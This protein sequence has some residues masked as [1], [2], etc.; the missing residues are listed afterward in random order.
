MQPIQLLNQHL[1][2]II[3]GGKAYPRTKVERIYAKLSTP[4]VA[5]EENSPG[6]FGYFYDG[7]RARGKVYPYGEVVFQ[8]HWDELK[9]HPNASYGWSVN[10]PQELGIT[11]TSVSP[12][13]DLITMKKSWDN[14]VRL[15]DGSINPKGS[16]LYTNHPIS[17]HRG[18][19][20]LQNTNFISVPESNEQV[21]DNRLGK[22]SPFVAELL[23]RMDAEKFSPQKAAIL[24]EPLLQQ[25]PRLTDVVETIHLPA[26]T[27]QVREDFD[28]E[29]EEASYHNL[30]TRRT[31]I[32][33]S[34]TANNLSS[35]LA[36]REVE[37]AASEQVRSTRIQEIMSILPTN[38]R[39]WSNE[40]WELNDELREMGI[41]NYGSI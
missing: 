26:A 13:K 36:Q 19:S 24:R 8:T 21:F 31:N 18:K 10:N 3:L 30:N 2:E 29:D 23:M 15:P 9:N 22:D 35:L 11:Q 16:G 41:T 7:N 27:N 4:K 33:P 34:E 6:K 32:P 17:N 28:W 5:L 40:H 39:S 38:R 37:R 12:I 20:Y 14:L 1:D 25:H